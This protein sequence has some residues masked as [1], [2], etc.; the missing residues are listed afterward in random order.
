MTHFIGAVVVPGELGKDFTTQPTEYPGLYGKAALSVRPGERLA[1]HLDEALAKFDEGREV[2]PYIERTKAQQIADER[3]RHARAAENLRKLKAG[4][5]P[6]DEPITD[7]HRNWIET[8]AP[9]L[10]LLDDDA[11]WRHIVEQHDWEERD[12]NGDIWTTYNPD[13]R[14]DWWTIG[15]RWEVVY[16]DR[17]G[18]PVS[19]LLKCLT[20]TR[21]G[22]AANENLNPHKGDPLAAGGDLPWYFPHDI[23]TS[24]QTWHRIGRTGWFG[25]RDS[26]MSVAEWVDHA[27]EALSRENPADSVIYIDFHI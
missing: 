16:R 21:S 15:G 24:D 7:A 14:W 8:E 12:S 10:S 5:K 6:Y 9:A 22:L 17:Q 4:E 3:E 25:F 13:S 2:E 26:D 23:V 19:A 1:M 18:E 20:E 11:L 27:I